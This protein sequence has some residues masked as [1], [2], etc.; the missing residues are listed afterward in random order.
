MSVT[1]ELSPQVEQQLHEEA[2]RRGEDAAGWA[3]MLLEEHFA[4]V[5]EDRGRRIA[6]LMA[7]WNEEDLAD[8]DPE[9]I[10]NIAPLSLREVHVD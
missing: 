2:A 9:P 7:Q 3:R 10:Q 6:A 1:L 8:P 4:T 5:R